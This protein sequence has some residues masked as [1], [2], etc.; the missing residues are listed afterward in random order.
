MS[1]LLTWIALFSELETLQRMPT[2]E[3]VD[4]EIQDLYKQLRYANEHAF[5]ELDNELVD[6]LRD[7]NR[8]LYEHVIASRSRIR[9]AYLD[10]ALRDSQGMNHSQSLELEF[11]EM[12]L[13]NQLVNAERYNQVSGIGNAVGDGAST[14]VV[15]N[16]EQ[17]Y[18]RFIDLH[19][20][21][22]VALNEVFIVKVSLRSLPNTTG[23]IEQI[24]LDL[25]LGAIELRLSIS[26]C[27]LF[28]SDQARLE[29]LATSDSQEQIFRVL[30]KQLGRQEA[31]LE[32]WQRGQQIANA[33][34][35][36]VVERQTLSPLPNQKIAFHFLPWDDDSTP[37]LRLMVRQLAPH[38]LHFEF[39]YKGQAIYE[40]EISLADSLAKV[41]R[42]LFE[43]AGLATDLERA[44]L[45]SLSAAQLTRRLEELG[46]LLWEHLLPEDFRSFYAANRQRW[47]VESSGDQRHS[48]EISTEEILIPWE[49]VRPF[50]NI[51]EPWDETAWCETF[52][53]ARWLTKWPGTK[54][55][56]FPTPWLAISHMYALVDASEEEIRQIPEAYALPQLLLEHYRPTI[57]SLQTTSHQKWQQIIG[58]DHDYLVHS[59]LSDDASELV[60][61]LIDLSQQIEPTFLEGQASQRVV[62]LQSV[63]RYQQQAWDYGGIAWAGRLAMLG[64]GL[65]VATLWSVSPHSARCFC[66]AFYSKLI[67]EKQPAG[68]AMWHARRAL[69][70]AGEPFW[71]FYSLIAHPLTY[72]K[73]FQQV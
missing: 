70:E 71:P 18:K 55:R 4:P 25:K 3:R 12:S 50:Q 33:H 14:N 6:I 46:N 59:F 64:A 10:D 32:V 38:Q 34:F 47:Y 73:V 45:P 26:N 60:A 54:R 68:V 67:D 16:E 35:E 56:V 8:E 17:S 7:A 72:I 22:T 9:A 42:G 65:T 20:P 69:K 44:R 48:F 30:A 21:Q 15:I 11:L 66:L 53:L 2:W 39:F 24:P 13:R 19:C 57:S 27:E 43:Q 58:E 5:K 61:Q 37:D 28:G 51:D 49:L 63:H 36:L 62:V 1:D 23:R 52:Y 29:V 31:C 41:V 40:S